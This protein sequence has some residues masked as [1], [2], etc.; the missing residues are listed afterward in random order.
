MTRRNRYPSRLEANQVELGR[1]LRSSR[2]F[3]TLE[4]RLPKG[5][6]DKDLAMAASANARAI[7]NLLSEQRQLAKDDQR[8][9]SEF[10]DDQHAEYWRSRDLEDFDRF[11]NKVKGIERK[12]KLL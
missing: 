4:R 7:A 11:T 3:S 1:R 2:R 12:G 10:S 8:T 6:H 9:L 5:T